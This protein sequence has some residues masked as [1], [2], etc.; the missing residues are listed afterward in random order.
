MHNREL[1]RDQNLIGEQMAVQNWTEINAWTALVQRNLRLNYGF[2]PGSK[3]NDVSA[4]RYTPLMIEIERLWVQLD[5]GRVAIKWIFA[6]MGDCLQAG[7]PSQYIT[8]TRVNLAFHFSIT[9]LCGAFIF[10]RWQVTLCDQVTLW[11]QL[12]GDVP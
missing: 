4:T 12:A 7:K 3:L 8:N 11:S 6:W 1:N 9:S 5:P 10:I 2:D